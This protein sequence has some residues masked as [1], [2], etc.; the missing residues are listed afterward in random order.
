M[1]AIDKVWGI[2]REKTSDYFGRLAVPTIVL[3]DRPGGVYARVYE[4]E[5]GENNGPQVTGALA[6]GT[7]VFVIGQAI[8]NG[9]D[10]S[11]VEADVWYEGQNYH[12]IGWIRNSLLKDGGDNEYN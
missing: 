11:K 3:W 12:Q 4:D 5:L 6:H 10:W 2:E 1:F 8:F 9:F 7:E